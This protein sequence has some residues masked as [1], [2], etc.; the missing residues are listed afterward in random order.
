MAVIRKRPD[1]LFGLH[2]FLG[3]PPL[4][5][6]ATLV[7]FACIGVAVIAR[8]LFEQM[9]RGVVP[10]VLTFPVVIVGTLVAGAGAGWIALAGCQT[11]TLLFVLPRW[12]R[13]SGDRPQEIVNLALATA[14]LALAVWATSSYRRLSGSLRMQCEREVHSLSL[15][16]NEMDHRTKNNFQIAASLLSTQSI[17]SGDPVVRDALNVAA[18]RL[19]SMAAVYE[20]LSQRAA[21]SGDV[22]LKAHLEHVCAALDA[23]LLVPGVSLDVA[24]DDVTVRAATALTIGLV[25]NEWV[26]NAVKY[27]FPDGAGAIAVTLARSPGRVMVEVR[28]DGI[29]IDPHQSGGTGSRLMASLVGA[30]NGTSTVRADGGTRCV[31]TVPL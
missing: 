24:G 19:V 27:A 5:L 22:P 12:V 9:F 14:S 29:G 25:V 26:T 7:G 1:R 18:G 2:R 10:F 17:A 13:D 11:L 31:L 16:I 28:D 21:G 4:D 3:S 30:L 15:L 23:S 6:Q 20:G 8:L